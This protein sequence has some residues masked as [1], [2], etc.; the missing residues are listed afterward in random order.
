M[1]DVN[2]QQEIASEDRLN[3]RSAGLQNRSR[4]R[5]EQ[6]LAAA[7][8]L[9]VETGIEGLK[10]RELARRARLPIASLYHY[11]PSSSSIVRAMAIR[12]LDDVRAVLGRELEKVVD[13]SMPID[14]R[15]YTADSLVRTVLDH[16][17][18]TPASATIWDSLRSSPELRQLD[19]EDTATN[20][21]ALEPYLRWVAPDLREE[22]IPML[23][24]V[25]LEALQ[26]NVIV[27]MHSPTD[28]HAN[29]IDA[30][31][32]MLTATLK[33]LQTLQA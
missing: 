33:G 21:R 16:L 18:R 11:F 2:Q 27:I 7:E 1:D 30:L 23:M 3:M 26:A 22:R 20:A 10:M 12:H 4:E 17:L 9:V 19:M 14:R 8:A 28:M 24:M 15:A 13:P 31:A 25:I 29:L 32:D 5:V 6:I